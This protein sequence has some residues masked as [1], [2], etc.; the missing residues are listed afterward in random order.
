M[1][2]IKAVVSVFVGISV[3]LQAQIWGF[4]AEASN[5]EEV[6]YVQ[7]VEEGT[8]NRETDVTNEMNETNDVMKELEAEEESSLENN[9]EIDE[10]Q[11]AD[12]TEESDE[13]TQLQNS[14]KNVMDETELWALLYLTDS[15]K[16]RTT[17]GENGESCVTI[18]SG[19]LVKI[20]GIDMDE[21]GSI[22]FRVS[23]TYN[24]T[25]YSGYIE[26]TYLACSNEKFVDWNNEFFPPVSTMRRARAS[27]YPDVEQFPESY[28]DELQKLKVAHP[29]WIF[30][31]Q[32]TGLNWSTVVANEDYETRSL[33]QASMPDAYKKQNYGAGWAIA[34]RAAVEYYL[35]PRNFINAATIFEFEHLT[36][37]ASYHTESAV[38]GIINNTFMSGALP[39][40]GMSYAHAFYEIG[41]ELKVSPFHLASRVYQE[42]GAGNSGLISGVYPGYEGYYNYYNVGA[43]GK[44]VTQIIESGLKEAKTRGWNTRYISLKG[45]AGVLSRDYISCG[46][47]TLYL[48]KFDVDNSSKQMYWHQYMQNLA[49]PSAESKKVRS[50]YEK[51]G[52]VENTFVFKIPVYNNMP[53]SACPVPG[54]APTPTATPTAKPTAKPTATPTATPTAKPT[55]T[56]TA[57]PTETPTSTPTV[58]PTA[59]PTVKPTAS[60]TSCGYRLC[61]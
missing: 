4:A 42:Q 59:T 34:S 25:D 23:F 51:S 53:E 44:T 37:N 1:K 14:L 19:T 45:G 46:Q 27:R 39:G 61:R 33:V 52:S 28:R 22:Y 47:D 17:P 48:E 15:Y 7:N 13:K 16:V 40:A 18:P 49:A 10:T 56:P 8:G 3:L 9:Q 50:A 2:N 36:F 43:F 38:Q 31:K 58:K 11:A 41:Q 21:E 5:I 35:D 6:P 32:N 30:V 24:D 29:N 20:T 60:W 57:K 12:E 54:K 26:K 55:S